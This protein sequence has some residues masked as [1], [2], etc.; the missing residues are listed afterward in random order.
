MDPL[1]ERYQNILKAIVI[2]YIRSAGPVGSRSLTKTFNLGL[3]PASIRNIMADLEELGYLMQPHPSAGRVPTEKAYRFYVDGLLTGIDPE[4]EESIEITPYQLHQTDDIKELLQ[5]TS[6]L[7]SLHSHYA[8][9]VLTPKLTNMSFQHI[10]FIKLM[11]KHQ[12]MTIFV[13]TEGLVQT[14]VIE[15]EVDFSQQELNRFSSFLNE[16]FMGIPL[17]EVRSQLLMQME[18]D[19]ELYSQL[20][21]KA[22][23]LVSKAF[24]EAQGKP[25]GEELFLEGT[26]NILELPEFSNVDKMK[27]LF[28]AFEEKYNMIKLLDTC[29][30]SEGIKVFIGSENA[31]WGIQDCSLVITRYKRGDQVLGAL[32]I[33]G[34]TRMEYSKVIP[35]VDYTAKLL[36]QTLDK[37]A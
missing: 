13:S 14:K 27:V 17:V 15:T 20:L 11:R 4:M 34:P 25:Q 19:K 8:G 16:R 35:L 33:I 18:A 6:R 29:F 28:K 9:I 23:D 24:Q 2:G 21:K 1:S 37:I 36:S 31:F 26:S 5:E 30:N 32:G 7:L 10:Q 22:L 3:S 12:V